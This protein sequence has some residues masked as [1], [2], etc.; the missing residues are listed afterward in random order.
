MATIEIIEVEREEAVEIAL[1]QEDHFHDVKAIEIAPAKLTRSLSAFANATGGE[2]YIG[3]SEVRIEGREEKQRKWRGFTTPEDANGHLQALDEFFPLGQDVN[4]T[5]L[6][7]E[8]APGLVLRVEVYK[9]RE[10]KRASDGEAYIRRGAQKIKVT[11]K[12]QLRRL[13]LDKGIYSFE[14]DTLDIEPDVILESSKFASFLSKIIPKAEP[15]PWLKKQRFIR[16]GKPNVAAILLFAEE[17]QAILPK[18]CALKIYRYETQDA[19]GSRGNL[20]FDPITVEGN[21]YEQIFESVDSTVKIIES[22]S[23]LGSEGLQAIEYPRETLHEIITNA[24]L[25]RDYSIISD[26]HIRVFDNRV[27]VESPGRLPGHIT[28]E[29][30]LNEQFA[31]NGSIVRMIN[32]F[33]DPP[34]KDVGEG[35]NTAFEAM[36]ELRLRDPEIGDRENSVI[37]FIRHEPLASPEESIMSYLENHDE[38]NNTTA[39]RITSIASENSVKK[40]FDRLRDKNLLEPVPGKRGR[41]SAWRKTTK[42]NETAK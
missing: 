19:M 31:R 32:K 27:E 35:L 4:Y 25:H 39:R 34:N 10:I 24:V 3:I 23:I 9:T 29:N 11:T 28:K 8:D 7:H 13:E 14:E 6:S 30:I 1:I 38:I 5:F 12:E 16:D 33:P 17:P 42:A 41:A 26:T 2:L 21:L 37:V 36:R 40:L 18:R 22:I 20:S 15:L